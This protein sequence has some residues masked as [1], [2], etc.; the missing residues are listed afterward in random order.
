[1]LSPT[2]SEEAW[3][4]RKDTSAEHE[5]QAVAA[6]GRFS[7]P[8]RYGTGSPPYASPVGQL[9]ASGATEHVT[10]GFASGRYFFHPV[11][12]DKPLHSTT[13]LL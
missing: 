11:G 5:R 3:S 10:A 4:H 7:L 2:K 12:N 13:I 9:R 1:L 8:E 6:I